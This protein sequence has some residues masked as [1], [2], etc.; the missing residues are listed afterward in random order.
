MDA[1]RLNSI[2]DGQGSHVFSPGSSK[3]APMLRTP[4]TEHQFYSLLSISLKAN[5]RYIGI[6]NLFSLTPGFTFSDKQS[7]ALY[8][9]AAKGASA[10]ENANLYKNTQ[11]Y[12]L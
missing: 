4:S 2:F 3:I 1:S 7:R 6:L 12:Y 8:I 5:N 11:Q 10:I 9:L